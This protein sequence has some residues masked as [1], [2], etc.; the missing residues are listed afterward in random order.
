MCL[1]VVVF[2][3]CFGLVQ[4]FTQRGGRR[5][6]GISNLIAG[7]D[8]DGTPNLYQTDPTGSH[9]SWKALAIGRNAKS[10]REFLEENYEESNTAEEKGD[11]DAP[12]KLAAK[13]L[14]EV[15]ESGAK[16]I[17]IAYLKPGSG[18]KM[19]PADKVAAICKEIEAEK[20]KDKAR[21]KKKKS[22]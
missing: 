8:A 11:E 14:L 17:E 13:A 10:V 16:N 18:L 21:G 5:P 6:F 19:V 7:F 12:I 22:T 3:L 2:C 20:E 1:C 15:V 4:R 9:T